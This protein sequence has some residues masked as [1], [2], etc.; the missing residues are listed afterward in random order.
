MLGD[1]VQRGEAARRRLLDGF[2]LLSGIAALSGALPLVT[3]LRIFLPDTQMAEARPQRAVAR[4]APV[5]RT[6]GDVAL[7]AR[8][9]AARVGLGAQIDRLQGVTEGAHLVRSEREIA[10]PRHRQGRTASAGRVCARFGA[11]GARICLR[12]ILPN[13][14]HTPPGVH[15]EPV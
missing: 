6:V 13:L 10:Q 4:V 5:E 7:Q 12:H 11:A 9:P 14:E 3:A 15:V 2:G 1:H 8:L